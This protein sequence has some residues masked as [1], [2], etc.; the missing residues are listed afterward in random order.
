[1]AN[2][3]L[4]PAVTS[5]ASATAVMAPASTPNYGNL[6]QGL[7]NNRLLAT[8][9]AVNISGTGDTAFLPLINVQ[10]FAFLPL[11]SSIILT[12]PGAFVNGVF[13]PGTSVA[14]VFQLFSGPNAT[15]ST[16]CASTTST[17]TGA[18]AALSIQIVPAT[19]AGYNLA[20]TWGVA[21]ASSYG[22][23]VHVTTA[24]AATATQFDM[25]VYGLDLT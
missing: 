11:A 1:M 17:M 25:Y 20:S 8:Q 19:L 3:N 10:A 15:G 21:N 16:I 7:N 14:C 24:S 22:I 9:K 12:N 6:Y 23:Y 4:G 2:V 13:T 18:T 5:N